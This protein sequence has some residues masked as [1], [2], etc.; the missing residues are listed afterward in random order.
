MLLHKLSD[1]VES[2]IDP[3]VRVGVDLVRDSIWLWTATQ[4]VDAA[5]SPP[6]LPGLARGQDCLSSG[7]SSR[8]LYLEALGPTGSR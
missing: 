8:T 3:V 7:E 4:L 6:R 2:A 5:Q 1:S